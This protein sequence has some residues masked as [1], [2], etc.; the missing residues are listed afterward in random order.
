MSAMALSGGSRLKQN[1]L[2]VHLGLNKAF[3]LFKSGDFLV[4]YSTLNVLPHEVNAASAAFHSLY[5][6]LDFVHFPPLL[7][8]Q[9][10]CWS[11]SPAVVCR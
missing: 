8:E 10:K 6:L 9:A 1:Y 2:F 11:A 5:T 7:V 3:Y 4:E